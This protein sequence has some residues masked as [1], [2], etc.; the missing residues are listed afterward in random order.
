METDRIQ[1]Q[2]C[3]TSFERLGAFNDHV[4]RCH[5]EVRGEEDSIY[6][7][8]NPN[9]HNN[10][11]QVHNSKRSKVYNWAREV[12]QK[13]FEM[14]STENEENTNFVN[15]RKN[16]GMM[17]NSIVQNENNIPWARQANR[18]NHIPLM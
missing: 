7:A 14:Q 9:K 12:V 18:A 11:L 15:V 5:P 4:A 1:C 2:Y 16:I 10:I 17:N 8:K 6:L 3:T 13:T